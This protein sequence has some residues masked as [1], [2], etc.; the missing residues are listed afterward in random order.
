RGLGP[1]SLLPVVIGV[2]GSAF[3]LRFAPPLVLIV[4]AAT[5]IATDPFQP[6]TVPQ[7][8]PA[9]NGSLPDWILS[10]ALL[11]YFAA[12]YRLLGL[13]VAYFPADTRAGPKAP[14]SVGEG[15][16]APASSLR[17]SKSITPSEMSG[18]IISLP[19]YAVLAQL[20]WK[21]VPSG[22]NAYGLDSSG[23][24]GVAFAWILGIGWSLAAG[25][26]SYVVWQQRSPSE[27]R[28]LLTDV[29]WRELSRDLRR[30]SRGISLGEQQTLSKGKQ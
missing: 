25:L 3:R 9:F 14:T 11:A 27:A 21:M 22:D 2:V 18:F 24:Q 1:W 12:H 16:G 20:I 26:L 17:G 15:N 4:L 8:T 19:V 13:T 5:L 7:I 28:M 23:W 30:A 6:A 29:V 10:A